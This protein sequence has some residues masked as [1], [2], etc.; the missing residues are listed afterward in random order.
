MMACK[1]KN[2][3]HLIRMEEI[4][5][6]CVF[7]YFVQLLED[8]NDRCLDIHPF[9]LTR[10]TYVMMTI[11]FGMEFFGVNGDQWL[12]VFGPLSIAI[13]FTYLALGRSWEEQHSGSSVFGHVI[14]N[15][16]ALYVFSQT[17]YSRSSWYHPVIMILYFGL[18]YSGVWICWLWRHKRVYEETDVTTWEG[19]L[20]LCTTPFL[21]AILSILN[22][23]VDL[24]NPWFFYG[25]TAVMFSVWLGRGFFVIKKEL[26]KNEL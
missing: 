26:S 4:F 5:F 22:I 20:K 16:L 9:Y 10:Q 3:I 11:Y 25:F 13:C 15:F 7:G 23:Y 12:K 17:L 24:S 6:L 19:S 21:G 1:E 14:I 2:D 8:W 18:H